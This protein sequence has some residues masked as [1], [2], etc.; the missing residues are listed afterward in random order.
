MIRIVAQDTTGHLTQKSREHASSHTKHKPRRKQSNRFSNQML[1]LKT[2]ALIVYEA[3]VPEKK[4]RRE[5][6]NQKK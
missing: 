2:S 6:Q 3:T 4:E 1:T 5:D